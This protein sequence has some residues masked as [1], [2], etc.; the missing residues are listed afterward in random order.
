MIDLS[1]NRDQSQI[2]TSEE[3]F[4]TPESVARRLSRVVS[5]GL[6]YLHRSV[7]RTLPE[8]QSVESRNDSRRSSLTSNLLIIIKK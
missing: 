8:S 1:I 2:V 4:V 7:S 3:D 5:D 6:N